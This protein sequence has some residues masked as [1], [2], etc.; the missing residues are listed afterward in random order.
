M[1]LYELIGVIIGDGCVLYD[2]SR[3]IYH[4]EIAGNVEEELEYHKCIK[5][6]LKQFT[7][8]DAKIIIRTNHLGKWLKLQFYNKKF[9]EFFVQEL[10]IQSPKA[11]TV[12]IPSQYLDWEFS[13]HILRGIF[14]TDGSLYFSRF[15]PGDEPKYPR[16]EFKTASI[17]L[18]KQILEILK[19]QNFRAYFMKKTDRA[20]TVTLNG[21]EM[22]DKWVKE[23]GFSTQKNK[24][25]YEIWKRLG[26]YTLRTSL[27]VRQKH[28][29]ELNA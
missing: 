25:K 4:L 18:A 16:L 29:V 26:F 20:Y 17:D 24:T 5:D 11:L 2:P 3:R 12:K 10:K 15:K 1:N 22:L 8:H 14:E 9:V 27:A 13:R 28:L 23:V 21:Y 6:F 7:G 19:R